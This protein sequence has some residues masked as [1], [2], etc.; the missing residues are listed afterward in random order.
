VITQIDLPAPKPDTAKLNLK[1]NVPVKW[2]VRYGLY[3]TETTVEKALGGQDVTEEKSEGFLDNSSFEFTSLKPRS[4]YFLIVIASD[5]T[6]RETMSDLLGFDTIPVNLA[7]NKPVTG[8]F[9]NELDDKYIETTKHPI[10]RVT[11]GDENYFSGFAKAW[12]TSEGPQWVSVDLGSVEQVAEAVIVWSALAVPD[13]YTVSTSPEG[14]NWVTE[15]KITSG[16]VE[17]GAGVTFEEKNSDNGDPLI[18][19]TIPLNKNLRF[20]ALAIPKDAGVESR[21]GW[22]TPV[23]AEFK[24]LAP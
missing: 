15:L 1:A 11:D 13:D 18:E 4:R 12:P 7:L 5:K 23:L 19:V 2:R 21:F 17:I 6:G 22:K 14:T 8:T 20:L 9:T 16:K 24:A 10:K 3:A